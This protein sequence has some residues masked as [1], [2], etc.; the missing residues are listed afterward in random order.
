V[1]P[2]DVQSHPWTQWSRWSAVWTQLHERASDASFFL[3]VDWV[4]TWLEVFGP[5]L[6]P[7]ILVFSE[8][9][10]GEPQVV[11]IALLSIRKQKVGPISVRRAYLNATGEAEADEVCSE[12]NTLLCLP[13]AED[14]VAG[15]LEAHLRTQDFDELVLNAWCPSPS[16]DALLRSPLARLSSARAEMPSPFVD[17]RALAPEPDGYLKSLSRNTREQLR[18]SRRSLEASGGIEVRQALTPARCKEAFAE[19]ARLHT[20]SWNARGKPGAFDSAVFRDFHERL[21]RRLL[22]SGRV[23]LLEIS[24]GD[25]KLAVLYGFVYA[26]SLLF[27]QS[28]LR[29]EP[30]KRVKLGLVAHASAIEHCR[31]AGLARYDFLAGTDQYKKSMASD[32][33]PQS[34]LVFRKRNAKLETINL[35]RKAKRALQGPRPSD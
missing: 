35:L 33:R 4:E 31:A 10:A 13:G 20:A 5:A 23:S 32:S 14:A 17:L 18:R 15:A 9:D 22:A 29:L 1:K 8:G 21:M 28:G 2:L 27:Y 16:L 25:L 30:D 3:T 26:G 6:R 12:D 34:W 11:G 19:L 24:A 7:Q